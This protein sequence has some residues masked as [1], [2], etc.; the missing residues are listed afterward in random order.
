[1]G[2]SFR[3]SIEAADRRDQSVVHRWPILLSLGISRP[4]NW[5]NGIGRLSQ[6][7]FR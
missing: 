2:I 3:L 1:M 7:L 4:F 5:A 6:F